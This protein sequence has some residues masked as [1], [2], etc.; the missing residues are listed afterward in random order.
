MATENKGKCVSM[1]AASDLSAAQY[2]FVTVNGSGKIAQTGDG[3]EADGILQDDPAAADR[4]G[5][6]MAGIGLSKVV[7]G[8]ATTAG[9][10]AASD[11]VGR[12][13]DA[14]TGDAVMGK[15]ME[16]AGAA[17]DI[18]TILFKPKAATAS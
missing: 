15:F 16:A 6:V 7:A 2:R 13:V 5:E 10:N 17:G 11:S 4:P 12:A 14:I 18:I 8:A 9:G 1:L 3:A